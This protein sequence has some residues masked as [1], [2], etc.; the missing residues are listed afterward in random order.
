M[1]QIKTAL[2]QVGRENR[3]RRDLGMVKLSTT[4]RLLKAIHPEGIPWPGTVFYN[5]ISATGIFQRN[6][7]LVARDVLNYCS[8]GSILDIGTGPGWLL[9]KLHQLSPQ[10][11]ITGLDASPSMVATARKN[12]A[13]AGLSSKTEV[14]VGNVIH[15]PFA[16]ESFDG[17][18]STGSIHHWK[19]PIDGLNEVYRVL[20]GGGYALMYDIVSDTPTSVLKEMAREHGR[21][22]IMLLWLHAFEEPFYRHK[23]FA[24]LAQPSLFKEGVTRF[25]GVLC[26]L[27]LRKGTGSIERN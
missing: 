4:R 5:A 15:I 24:L 13:A 17:V 25:V 3:S 26:C 6:Y 9:V 2:G 18:V 1:K 8:R 10:L 16:A 23:D 12:M 19:K 21:L 27:I 22:K 20:K 11:H 7:E 14:R